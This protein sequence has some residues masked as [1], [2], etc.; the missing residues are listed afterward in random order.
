V[1]VTRQ[2]EKVGPEEDAA[3]GTRPEGETKEPLERGLGTPP[4]PLRLSDLRRG[5]E[6]KAGEDG[7]G[8][9]GH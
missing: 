2:V 8:D 6:Q 4:E 1:D 9:D 3:G 7:G 5:R